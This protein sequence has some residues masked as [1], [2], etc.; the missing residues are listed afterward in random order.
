MDGEVRRRSVRAGLVKVQDVLRLAGF[1]HL[2]VVALEIGDGLALG[3]GH[4]HVEDDHAGGALDGV[5]SSARWALRTGWAW[6]T[7][8]GRGRLRRRRGR[9]RGMSLAG[10]SSRALL[11][12][13][14]RR[15]GLRLRR[16]RLRTDTDGRAVPCERHRDLPRPEVAS[17]GTALAFA[18]LPCERSCRQ[19]SDCKPAYAMR[20]LYL[21]A[22]AHP[23]LRGW[24]VSRFETSPI[25]PIQG[26][27][28]GSILCSGNELLTGQLDP[29]NALDPTLW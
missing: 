22:I 20:G 11:R 27:P 14:N 18:K 10:P 26:A 1:L 17:S 24:H 7:G 29:G 13:G 4:D 23:V 21:Q 15:R 2:K 28:D 25:H 5:R 6:S 9:R 16:L 8:R 3:V 12:A 19:H